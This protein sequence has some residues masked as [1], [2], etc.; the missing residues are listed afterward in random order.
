MEE[1]IKDIYDCIPLEGD[2]VL[3][4]WYNKVIEKKVDEL[5]VSDVA[6]CIRQNLFIETTYEALLAYLLHNPYEGDL[7]EGELM[8]KAS[9]VDKSI[10]LKHKKTILEVID[11][12]EAFSKDNEWLID[13][14]RIE[15]DEAISNLKKIV[16]FFK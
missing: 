5:S 10:I 7:Y 11:S 8:E 2:D 16:C 15:F 9:K 13:E 14:D 4:E 6:R 1:K 12:A 3:V